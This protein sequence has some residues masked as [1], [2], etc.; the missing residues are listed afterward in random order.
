MLTCCRNC[1]K[2]DANDF[3]FQQCKL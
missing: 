3:L 1:F 2:A